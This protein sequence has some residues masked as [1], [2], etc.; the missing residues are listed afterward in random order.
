MR[1]DDGRAGGINVIFKKNIRLL[2]DIKKGIKNILVSEK[3]PESWVNIIFTGD[4]MIKMINLE[5]RMKNRETDVIAF[6]FKGEKRACPGGDVFISLDTAK[7]NA[8]KYGV[9]VNEELARLVTHGTLHVLGYDHMK[10]KDEREME[11][12]TVKYM[13]YFIS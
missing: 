4:G 3:E 11:A 7:K 12:K 8:K 1:T 13:K 2:F 5:Y 6:E 10:V 9:T